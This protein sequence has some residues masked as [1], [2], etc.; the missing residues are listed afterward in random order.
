MSELT[1]KRDSLDLPQDG[2]FIEFNTKEQPGK[3]IATHVVL[4]SITI[5][6]DDMDTPLALDLCKHPLYR[7]LWDYCR[8]NPPR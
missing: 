4:D 6:A 1:G 2:Y 5:D 7:K 8:M 3:L